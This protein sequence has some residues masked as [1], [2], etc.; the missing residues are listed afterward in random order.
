MSIFKKF[1]EDAKEGWERGNEK[2][3]AKEIKKQELEEEGV[4]YCPECL[5]TNIQG[6]KAGFRKGKA[7][8][9]ALI[10]GPLGLAAG[11]IGSG[12]VELMCLECGNKWKP[13]K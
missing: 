13:K 7:A 12:K 1:I 3:K 9:G 11:G 2:L 5:S 8:A 10:A 6:G 4:I